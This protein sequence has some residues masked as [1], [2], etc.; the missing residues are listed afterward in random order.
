ML[1]RIRLTVSRT[2]P[3]EAEFQ[4]PAPTMSL[5]AM[6]VSPKLRRA[7]VGSRLLGEFERRAV[8]MKGRSMHLSTDADNMIARQFYERHGWRPLSKSADKVHYGSILQ[9]L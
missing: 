1:G 2:V 9:A 8:G 6:G 4:L 7:G 3:Q 5:V